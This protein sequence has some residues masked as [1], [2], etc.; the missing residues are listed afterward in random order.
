MKEAEPESIDQPPRKVL[1]VASE[2]DIKFS[3]TYCK[4]QDPPVVQVEVGEPDVE[5]NN[6]MLEDVFIATL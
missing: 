5:D 1:K 2:A 4:K 3:H 6:D